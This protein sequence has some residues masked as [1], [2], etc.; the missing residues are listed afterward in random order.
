MRPLIVAIHGILTGQ[1]NASWPDKLDAWL[2]ARDPRFKVLK[3]EYAAG[4][5]PRW[6]CLV[7]DPRL[8]EGLANEIALFQPAC[9]PAEAAGE[10][11]SPPIWVVAHS[12]GAVIALLATKRLI[13][14]GCWI[15]GLI[16]IGAACEAEI[17]RNGVLGWL[18]N[19][20]LGAAIAFC[21]ADDRVL[22][23]GEERSRL[24]QLG[25]WLWR[26]LIWPYG[27]LGRTGWLH[28]GKPIG[29]QCPPAQACAAATPVAGAALAVCWFTGGHSAYFNEANLTTTFELVYRIVE[30]HGGPRQNR[31]AD[32]SPLL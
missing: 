30:P 15:G 2:F 32:T 25:R 11:D 17:G 9:S 26:K 22:G 28:V 8:A 19:G 6:N 29:V 21:C 31:L 1:T 27:T 24:R 3:K 23:G 4:P 7:R 13:A 14:R 16:L 12:N 10:P 20:R 5:F 18:Q